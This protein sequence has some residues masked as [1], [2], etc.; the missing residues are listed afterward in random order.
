M[1]NL[2]T[3]GSLFLFLISLR[4]DKTLQSRVFGFIVSAARP[5]AHGCGCIVNM[6]TIH[7]C[8]T[9]IYIYIYILFSKNTV[10]FI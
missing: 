6:S 1:E 9:G 5:S 4:R 10:T 3:P 7:I 8:A 2:N